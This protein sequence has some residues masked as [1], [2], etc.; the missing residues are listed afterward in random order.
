MKFEEGCSQIAEGFEATSGLRI[1][2]ERV[3]E[4]VKRALLRVGVVAEETGWEVELRVLPGRSVYDRTLRKT[5]M[6]RRNHD[7][8]GRP[9]WAEIVN[10]TLTTNGRVRAVCVMREY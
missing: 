8:N 1:E 5:V 4:S 9:F 3:V 7:M 10:V 6:R 2:P